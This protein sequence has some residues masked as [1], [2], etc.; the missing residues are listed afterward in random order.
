MNQGRDL[1]RSSVEVG[2]SRRRFDRHRG[3]HD[4]RRSDQAVPDFL[5]SVGGAVG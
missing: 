4:V 5:M 3:V 1:R 2:G